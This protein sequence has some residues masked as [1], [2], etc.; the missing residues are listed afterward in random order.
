MER[1]STPS[2]VLQEGITGHDAAF[3]MI[4]EE[5]IDPGLQESLDFPDAIAQ[6]VGVAGRPEIG[7]QKDV[8]G[9]KGIRM[10]L[11]P[12]CMGMPDKRCGAEGSRF[13]AESRGMMKRFSGPT[14]RAYEAILGRQHLASCD[15]KHVGLRW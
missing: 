12:H 1:F 4:S 15:T 10:H 3:G 8:L 14:P 7:R 5:A 9:A 13:P 11:E 6:D 2:L